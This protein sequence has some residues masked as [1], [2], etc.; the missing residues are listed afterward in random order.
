MQATLMGATL[1][2]AN[3]YRRLVLKAARRLKC[4]ADKHA[5][6]LSMHMVKPPQEWGALNPIN[7]FPEVG[8]FR[9]RLWTVA[10]DGE[11]CIHGGCTLPG[12]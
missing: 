8:A 2:A 10:E 11:E 7:R 6:K 5:R 4:P 1:A 9:W 3:V 12:A